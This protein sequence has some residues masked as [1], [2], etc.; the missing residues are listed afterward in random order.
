MSHKI[1]SSKRLFK[2][3]HQNVSSKCLNQMSHQK[4]YIYVCIINR[5]GVAVAVL[6]SPPLL[7]H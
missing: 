6:Q 2:M 5:P 1:V 3:C 4:V 7:I